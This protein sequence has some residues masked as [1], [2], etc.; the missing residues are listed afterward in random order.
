MSRVHRNLTELAEL[1]LLDLVDEGNAK[2]PV[3][4]YDGVSV[5]LPLVDTGESGEA[6]A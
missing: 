4:W 2:R 1:H 6:S 3:V 5:D